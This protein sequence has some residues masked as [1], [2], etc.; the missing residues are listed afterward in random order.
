MLKKYFLISCKGIRKHGKYLVSTLQN[1][2]QKVLSDNEVSFKKDLGHFPH[3]SAQLKGI[4][5]ACGII[6]HTLTLH[7]YTRLSQI[8]HFICDPEPSG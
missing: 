4:S 7:C 6:A 1:Q 8:E 2:T 5:L 3:Q